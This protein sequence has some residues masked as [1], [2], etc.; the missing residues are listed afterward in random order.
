[1]NLS[2]RLYKI[3]I[4]SAILTGILFVGS[5]VY[6]AHLTEIGEVTPLFSS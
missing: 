5:A 2:P 1:M 4:I 3:K 6:Y